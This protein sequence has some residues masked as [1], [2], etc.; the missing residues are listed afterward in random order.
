MVDFIQ[1]LKAVLSF[2]FHNMISDEDLAQWD[3]ICLDFSDEP[4]EGVFS[5][6]SQEGDFSYELQ[7]GDFSD[8]PTDS[9][10]PASPNNQDRY[11][12]EP[13]NDVTG[14]PASSSSSALDE[15]R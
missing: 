1:I 3:L 4:Q 9:P 13:N 15:D 12:S 11:E 5:Y 2:H 8:E 14:S 7:E 6:G 10:E